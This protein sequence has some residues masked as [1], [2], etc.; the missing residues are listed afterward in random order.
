MVER[1]GFVGPGIMGRPM[2]LN[3]LQAG[4]P[5]WVYARTPAR[6]V[7]LAERGASLCPTPRDVGRAADIVITMVSDTSDVEEVL[8][9]DDGVIAGMQEGGLVVD[10]STIAPAATRRMAKRF[11][12]QQIAMLDAPVSG[13]DVGARAGTLSI[14]VGGD[15]D[16]YRRML[17]LF[18][19][20]GSSIVHVG[21]SGAG[22]VAKVCNQLV[23]AANIAASADALLFA[24]A[25]GVDP[26]KVREA[27]LGGF[28]ASKVLEV[29]GQR[30]LDRNFEP[31]FKLKLHQKD[32][33]IALEAIADHGLELRCVEAVAAGI[34]EAVEAG[35]GEHDTSSVLRVLEGHNG[36]ELA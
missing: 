12:E 25:A 4:Y 32:L 9:G 3:L 14:M 15:A 29:H 8:L 11:A 36:I 21:E 34:Q 10:M 2:A 6:A 16:A 27:L 20:M 17:P 33:R 24:K 31:G 13:G 5:V 26:A 22:Q 23:V 19:V 7:S 1:I 30:M 18:E 35:W 28:A